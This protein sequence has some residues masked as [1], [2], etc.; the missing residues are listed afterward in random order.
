VTFSFKDFATKWL[1]FKTP[2]HAS[3]V[4][5]SVGF[6]KRPISLRQV[7]ATAGP[8]KP[9]VSTYPIANYTQNTTPNPIV[10]FFWM[11]PANYPPW[12][13][14]SGPTPDPRREATSWNLTVVEAGGEVGGPVI[15]VT[16]PLKNEA[17]G[18]V[19]YD[20]TSIQLDGVYNCQVTAYNSYGSA[21]AGRNN[22]GIIIP[23]TTPDITV[24]YTGSHNYKITGS[25]F[26]PGGQVKFVAQVS[27]FA[28]EQT[29][30]AGKKGSISANMN[31]E[32]PCSEA[33][34]GT[35]Q[36]QATD[37]ATGVQSNS[38]TQPCK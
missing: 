11:D 8:Y 32:Q 23:G 7:M 31:C 19:Q 33:K 26:T 25:G 4:A 9:D 38:P 10:S 2:L 20:Y 24:V 21:A 5:S 36:F 34:G 17:A 29:D 22:V 27:G 18:L 6:T 13:S 28:L 16:V 35:L 37:Q 1:N 3:A 14:L 15:D 12:V 30:A